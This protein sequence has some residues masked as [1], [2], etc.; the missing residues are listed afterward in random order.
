[1]AWFLGLDQ[2]RHHGNLYT[3]GPAHHLLLELFT[4]GKE[5]LARRRASHW[6]W[7]VTLTHE[8]TAQHSTETCKRGVNPTS[9][10]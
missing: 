9:S 10:A 3:R 4:S 6:H 8:P 1:M 7:L 2:R 5:L